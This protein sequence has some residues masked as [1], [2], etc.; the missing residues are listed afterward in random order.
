MAEP[1]GACQQIQANGLTDGCQ[2]FE[3][4]EFDPKTCEVCGCKRGFHLKLSVAP[5]A[6]AAAGASVAQVPAPAPSAPAPLSAP[7]KQGEGREQTEWQSDEMQQAAK[8][9]RLASSG[10]VG[11]STSGGGS[12][13]GAGRV[14]DGS[15]AQE[16]ASQA[17]EQEAGSRPPTTLQRNYEKCLQKFPEETHGRYFLEKKSNGKW[18][19]RCE[20]C[21]QLMAIQNHTLSNFERMHVDG[22]KHLSRVTAMREGRSR[23]SRRS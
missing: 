15:A 8:K 11:G 2:E 1:R 5:L 13:T 9:P 20:P 10:G 21:N 18:G 19:I 23:R 4:E 16:G 17:A 12:A 14:E 22:T 3:P 6:Q 7:P